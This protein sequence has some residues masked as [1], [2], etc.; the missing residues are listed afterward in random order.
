MPYFGHLY[1][2]HGC[3]ATAVKK[4][5]QPPLSHTSTGKWLLYPTLMW[6]NTNEGGALAN[7]VISCSVTT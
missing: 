1:A 4:T 2:S 3:Q 5:A 6:L 7:I